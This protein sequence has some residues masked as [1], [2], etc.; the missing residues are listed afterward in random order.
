MA[1]TSGNFVAHNSLGTVLA[2]RDELGKAIEHYQTALEIWPDYELAQYNMGLAL[3]GSGKVGEA[4]SHFERALAIKP[5]HAAVLNNLAWIRATQPDPR[6]RDGPQAVRLAQRAV[7]LSPGD[8][9]ALDTLAAA[10]AEAG[11]FAD[12]VRTAREA[13]QA[14][15]TA[16]NQ[17]LAKSLGQ[18]TSLYGEGKP[19][20]DV[21]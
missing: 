2:E 3:V 7:E 18:R 20:R 6:F 8:A 16:G 4:I 9:N 11:Q 15:A 19:W 1:C 21:P 17:R 5:N 14:A 12:A 13:R 10:Y